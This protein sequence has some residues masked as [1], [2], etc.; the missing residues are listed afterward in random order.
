M[1]TS[2]EGWAFGVMVSDLRSKSRKQLSG[3]NENY[4]GLV[5]KLVTTSWFGQGLFVVPSE[6]FCPR[7]GILL[8]R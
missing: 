1:G 5:L 3:D 2:D 8:Y 7:I 6:C 4:P